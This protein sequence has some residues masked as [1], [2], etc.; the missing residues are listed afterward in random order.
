MGKLISVLTILSLFFLTAVPAQAVNYAVIDLGTLGGTNSYASDINANG[1]VVGYSLLADGSQHAFIYRDGA[2]HD[3]GTL[4]GT[5]SEARAINSSGY[6]VGL[7]DMADGSQHAFIYRDGAMHDLGTLGGLQSIANDIND[8]G[9]IVG[10][11]DAADGSRRA[12]LY[13]NGVMQNID[14][15]GQIDSS[16]YGIN[17]KGQIVGAY[18]VL[19]GHSL[20]DYYTV[21]AFYIGDGGMEDL[22]I[23]SI[24]GACEINDDGT[25]I[26]MQNGNGFIYKDEN[27]QIS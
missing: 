6:V 8:N 23:P 27:L 4:G 12:F 5:N 2:M 17:N 13:N 24:T 14:T 19:A 7:S 10:S 9:Q 21:H 18:T 25:I 3:L 15:L 1:Q 26:G 22:G 11:S 16:A 20:T